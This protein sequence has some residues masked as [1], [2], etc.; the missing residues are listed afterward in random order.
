MQTVK[1][2]GPSVRSFDEIWHRL[3]RIEDHA[4]PLRSIHRVE[5]VE[6]GTETAIVDWE[7][8]L[9][10]SRLQWR[11]TQRYLPSE[12]AVEF[13]QI[14]GDLSY[15]RGRWRVVDH[16]ST[17]SV[18]VEITFEIGVRMLREMLEPIAAEELKTSLDEILFR[19][20]GGSLDGPSTG[21]GPE[22]VVA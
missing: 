11:Q 17:C 4:R 18:E 22:E 19:V 13:E 1:R 6:P 2:T 14:D 21:R 12:L 3:C 20:G 8:D 10:G 15:L 5:V 7:V 9:R 16:G